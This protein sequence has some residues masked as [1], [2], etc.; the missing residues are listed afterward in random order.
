MQDPLLISVI[1]F[2]GSMIQS[3]TGFGLALIAVPLLS[4]I[5]DVKLS[6]PLALIFSAIMCGSLAYSMKR[7]IQWKAVLF[8]FAGCIPGTFLGIAIL[9]TISQEF[10]L[11]AMG[12]VIAAYCLYR[13]SS[14]A[15]TYRT[16]KSWKA[17]LFGFFSG[18]LGSAVGESGPPI[19]L[20]STMQ[21]WNNSQMKATMFMFFF[22]Q[23]AVAL[24]G[25]YG[26]HMISGELLSL[27]LNAVPGFLLGIATGL[28]L[29][30]LIGTK[31]QTLNT[32]INIILLVNA[33]YTSTSSVIKI[34]NL[35]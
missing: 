9:K 12:L 17:T 30:R 8:L 5:L 22:L 28:L 29:Y 18:V 13:I 34:M 1:I 16:F 32:L 2:F 25:Y 24:C 26:Q 10:I 14:P 21:R 19:V 6:I 27:T 7:D 15:N 23:V 35:S 3:C 31:Q 33:I 4:Q 20:F 11:F